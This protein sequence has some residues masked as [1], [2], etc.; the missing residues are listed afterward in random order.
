MYIFVVYILVCCRQWKLVGSFKFSV[1]SVLSL[2]PLFLS[3]N[4]CLRFILFFSHRACMRVFMF[5]YMSVCRRMCVC[6]RT[7]MSDW[8]IVM[9]PVCVSGISIYGVYFLISYPSARGFKETGFEVKQK[10]KDNLMNLLV[11]LLSLVNPCYYIPSQDI[12]TSLVCM[13]VPYNNLILLCHIVANE[14]L[15]VFF[16]IQPTLK[17]QA[18]Q[19]AGGN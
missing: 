10:K 16:F 12:L 4:N 6:A 3:P 13:N 18:W 17:N 8:L 2:S 15:K 11:K 14:P 1:F 7:Y 5:M 19:L 9:T